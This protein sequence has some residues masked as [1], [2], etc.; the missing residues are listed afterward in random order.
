MC[1]GFPVS[2]RDAEQGRGAQA[3]QPHRNGELFVCFEASQYMQPACGN[4]YLA[5]LP[6]FHVYGMSL[7]T[8]GLL[9]LGSTVVFDTA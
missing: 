4:V 7:F 9:S 3:P 2:T 1:F 5:S 8:M 6:M